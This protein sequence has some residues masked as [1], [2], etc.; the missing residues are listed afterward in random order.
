M[1]APS[2]LAARS[3]PRVP[4]GAIAKGGFDGESMRVKA[5]LLVDAERVAPGERL[6]VGVLFDLDPGWH[7]Y[8][9]SPGDAGLPTELA[10]TSAGLEVGPTKWTTPRAFSESEG[11]ITT[12]GYADRAFL[13]SDARVAEDASGEIELRVAAKFLVCEIACVPGELELART[14]GVAGDRAPADASEVA[15]FDEASRDAPRPAS[16]LGLE[17]SAL[18]SQS[19]IRP[20]DEFEAAIAIGCQGRSG[21]TPPVS[22][23]EELG[24]GFIPDLVPGLELRA[25]RVRPHPY[26]PGDLLIEL[27]G[28]AG[29][30]EPA[31][32]QALAGVVAL[33]DPAT[34]R[35]FAAEVSLPLPRASAGSAVEQIGAPWREA[36]PAAQAS[37]PAVPLGLAILYA[38]L[39]G[40]ILNLMP[41]VL[42]VLAIKVFAITELAHK[43]HREVLA[44]GAAYAAG[45]V[46]SMIA[47]ALAVIALRAGGE[48]IGWG[49]QFQDPL[50]VAAISVVLVVFALNLFGVFEI[51]A[52][53]GALAGVGSHGSATRRSF[54]EGLLAVV[55][56]TPCSAP[57]LGTAVGF[58]FAASPL[59][60][61]AI[62]ASIGVGLALP[63]V[64]VTLVPAWARFLPRSGAWMVTLRKG[65]GFAVLAP[66]VWLVSIVGRL[67]GIDA[68]VALLALLVAAG[69][70]A[71]IFGQLQERGR[72]FPA[73]ALAIAGVL[74]ASL[75]LPRMPF[76]A[77]G[78]TADAA[79]E[80]SRHA[81]A[82][83]REALA[84]A[85]EQGRPVFVYFTADWCITCKVNEA[86]ALASDDVRTTFDEL[87]VTVLEG[88]WT[89]RNAAIAAELARFGKAGVPMY[90]VY[91]PRKPDAPALLPEL[92]T[93]RIVID[94]V[95]AAAA[96]SA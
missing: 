78:A 20:R 37:A 89:Q 85:L 51:F 61:V 35:A 62:F 95:R 68:V 91:D 9:R 7:I 8:W 29:A 42:P 77:S 81:N 4:A 56:A 36:E 94:A 49:F 70:V 10:W 25:T 47:L 92:L 45:V 1:C 54:F 52:P 40:L 87:G 66:V 34:G 79:S 80:A 14:I 57:F 88:D 22:A 3:A 65:L 16:A 96:K 33:R 39:G 48:S 2:A 11:L 5:R 93:P 59:V 32:P 63:F 24:W 38:L 27:E 23:A 53:T 44:H 18:F 64:L 15:F 75:A 30:A 76:D 82:Y 74:G 26:S 55:L 12:Y 58:A 90:L 31:A 67:A 71:W 69:F 60:I 46:G 17:A 50:F 73:R 13:H 83:S 41:C 86:G 72:M 84:S 28:L 21:C 43:H 6:R 19:A